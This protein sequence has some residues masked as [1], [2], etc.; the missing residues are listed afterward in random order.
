MTRM[1]TG[2]PADTARPDP[3]KIGARTGAQAVV[4]AYRAGLVAPGD[5]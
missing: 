1:T 5:R 4:L 2:K 3:A